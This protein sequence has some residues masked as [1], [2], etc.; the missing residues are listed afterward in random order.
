MLVV[1]PELAFAFGTP[2]STRDVPNAESLNRQLEHT[3]LERCGQSPGNQ[4]S[5]VGGWQSAPDLLNWSDTGVARLR[6]EI[7]GAI[8]GLWSML[9]MIERRSMNPNNRVNY[10]S[11]AWANV[12][13]NGEYN[14]PHMHPGSDWSVVYYV[15]TGKHTGSSPLNGQIELRDP[16]PAAAYAMTPIFNSGQS[17]LF[18]PRAGLMMIFPAWID[19]WVHPFYGDG[20]RISIAANIT[21]NRG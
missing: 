8:Q 12:N 19:H 15:A 13:R 9:A 18:A 4:L 11:V 14:M 1:S 10:H 5:N 2:V 6:D 21:L 16:R 7:D 3:I 17:L 20:H